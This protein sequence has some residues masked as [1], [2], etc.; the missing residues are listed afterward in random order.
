[1]GALEHQRYA[2]AHP[3]TT[4]IDNHDRPRGG[5][6][7]DPVMSGNLANHNVYWVKLC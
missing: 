5:T 6:T 7:I 1:M 4:T 2:E 3:A